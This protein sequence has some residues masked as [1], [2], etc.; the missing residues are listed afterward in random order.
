MLL[1]SGKKDLLPWRVFRTRDEMAMAAAMYTEGIIRAI[2]Q[3]QDTLAMIFAAAPSQREFL[4]YL[5]S[6][7][8]IPWS[9]ITAFH[10]DEYLDLPP[11]APQRFGNFLREAIFSRVTF[12]EV[13]YIPAD[14]KNNAEKLCRQ[15]AALLCDSPA[16]ICCMGIGENGHLAF[17]DPP[18]ADFQDENL[19]KMVKL[20]K[21]CRRQQVND[22]CFATLDAVPTHAV[23]LTIPALMACTHLVCVVPGPTK[24][25]AI[26][27]L[28]TE[29]AVT[30]ANP[31]SILRTHAG[32]ALFLD[33]DS[34][35]MR[36]EK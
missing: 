10:M 34:G 13:H 5:I 32:A 12:R 11:D 17:N 36:N 30:E 18:V 33:S 8:D 3:Q 27:R 20:D 14:T 2:L 19:V 7:P 31:A 24:Q 29:D 1:Q 9:R 23:T 15:Y 6:S 35:E 16:D 28:L 22:G 4:R 26:T 25:S 21:S